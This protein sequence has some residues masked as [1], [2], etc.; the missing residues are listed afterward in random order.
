MRN[1]AALP[2][3]LVTV[4]ILILALPVSSTAQ[5]TTATLIGQVRDSSGGVV[6]GASVVATNEGTGVTRD[7]TSD[8]NGEFV[9]SALSA[10]PYTVKIDLQGFKTYINKGLQLGSGLTVRQTFALELGT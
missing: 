4:L 1:V 5:V 2:V 6:P 3:L 9:L 10:G 7:A 8:A